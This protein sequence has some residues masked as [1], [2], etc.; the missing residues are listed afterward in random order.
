MTRKINQLGPHSRP[1]AI[2]VLD[3]RTKEAALLRK[4]RADL[5]A[6]VGGNP[7]ATQRMLIDRAARLTL[8][9]ELFERRLIESGPLS[10]RD[11]R[12]YL[13]YSNALGRTL[14]LLG[15]KPATAAPPS[16]EQLFRGA[17]SQG[18][19]VAA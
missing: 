6:H 12:D 9:C 16:P 13:A 15:M 2:A 8:H 4:V 7:S 3:G 11:G 10:E 17:R 1:S 14:A 5:T 18:Q 19:G